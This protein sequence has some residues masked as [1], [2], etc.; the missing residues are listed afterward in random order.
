MQSGVSTDDTV[1]YSVDDTMDGF[2]KDTAKVAADDTAKVTTDDIVTEAV[3][4]TANYLE[5]NADDPVQREWYNIHK[6]LM[7][8]L[9]LEV[10]VDLCDPVFCL[11]TH[12]SGVNSLHV[13]REG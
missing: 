6:N 9:E 10:A 7:E 12:Q 11:S 1:D 3:D 5:D 8:S 13:L 2:V 4:D